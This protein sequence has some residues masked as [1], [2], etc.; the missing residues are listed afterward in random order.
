MKTLN[1]FLLFFFLFALNSYSL[2]ECTGK[3]T[4]A[5]DLC[6]GKASTYE[7]EW[8]SRLGM[9]NEYVSNLGLGERKDFNLLTEYASEGYDIYFIKLLE[10]RTK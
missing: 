2:P 8:K 4:I 6:L 3:E 7:G 10:V 5:W 9:V 1:L